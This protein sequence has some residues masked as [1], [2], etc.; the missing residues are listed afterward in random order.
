VHL[1]SHPA[2]ARAWAAVGAVA[3]WV[4]GWWRR[5]LQL[6]VVTTTLVASATVVV[7]LGLVLLDQFAQG[8][9][10]AQLKAAE[11]ET[12]AGVDFARGQLS[13]ESG[14]P[15]SD[16]EASLLRVGEQLSGR[17]GS[18]AV[19]DIWILPQS[20]DLESITPPN[21]GRTRIPAAV[22][23]QVQLG[24]LA[25]Q[26]TRLHPP[27]ARS[28]PG[29]VVG[30]PVNTTSDVFELYYVFPL[31]SEVQTIEL[32]KRTLFAAGVVLVLLLAIVA[33]LVTRQVVSPVRAAARTAERLSAGLLQERMDVRGEDDLARL[34]M[35]FNDMAASL[36][37]Q[38]VQLEELSRV[39]RRFT[40][41]VSHELRTPLT[42]VRMA[43]DVLHSARGD[44]APGVARSAELLQ[45]EVDRFESL[46]GDLL[47]ISRYDAGFATLE[48]EPS[49][50][51][52]LVHSAARTVQHLADRTGTELAFDLPDAPVVAEVD[53]RRVERILRNL[54]GNAIDHGAGKPV[55]V[56]LRGTADALAVV[57]RDHGIGLKPGESSLVFNRFWRAD[58]SR[59]RHTGGTGLGLSI[60]L[61]DA[62]LHGGWLQAWGEPGVGAQFRLTLP[63]HQP[64]ELRSSPLPLQPSDATEPARTAD[65][66]APV[67]GRS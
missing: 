31:S 6:R 5:S 13:A 51:A 63:V 50:V 24:N 20:P 4:T 21:P 9:L 16:I 15:N 65:A 49:D 42:T 62:H 39:Q 17:G 61:E 60:S 55:C 40:S 33:A 43:A 52:A 38:I 27:D 46:L 53:P 29:L 67:T 59:A 58:P 41:D 48:A 12:L 23:K 7:L 8:V 18:G 34:A 1:L 28:V 57:V 44:F 54:M 56:T 2:A 32:V 11:T 64:A 19:Y 26:Y 14:A 45:T 37:H 22:R 30:A 35:S 10:S 36:Q 25:Y 66:A 3:R 47:E